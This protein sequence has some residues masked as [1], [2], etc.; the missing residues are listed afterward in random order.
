MP[1]LLCFWFTIRKDAEFIFELWGETSLSNAEY[2]ES[3]MLRNRT[4]ILL[5]KGQLRTV[6]HP[7]GSGSDQKDL[8][9][10]KNNWCRDRRDPSQAQD[11]EPF[12]NAFF[13]TI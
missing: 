7:E 5:E 8:G 2:S 11:D 6:R 10:S 1:R 13:D 4:R 3:V 9:G 12:L